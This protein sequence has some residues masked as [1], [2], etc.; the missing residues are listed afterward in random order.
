MAF[1]GSR[2][3][4]VGAR[5]SGAKTKEILALAKRL[6]LA[7]LCIVIPYCALVAAEKDA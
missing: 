4:M 7:T 5:D 2:L 1:K 3:A 6:S